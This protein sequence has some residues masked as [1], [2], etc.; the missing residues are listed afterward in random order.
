MMAKKT[1]GIVKAVYEINYGQF[2]SL[3]RG[4]S[5]ILSLCKEAGALPYPLHYITICWDII[6]GYLDEWKEEFQPVLRKRKEENE[7][8]MA[9]FRGLGL[10]MSSVPFADYCDVFYCDEP[11]ASV[12]ECLCETEEYLK[13][14]GLRDID[15]ELACCVEKFQFER[16]E[17]LLKQGADPLKNRSEIDDEDVNCATRVEKEIEFLYSFGQDAVLGKRGIGN[18]ESDLC[19][20]FGLAAH[21]KMDHLLQEYY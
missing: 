2:I 9:F 13:G 16:A 10:D 15:I 17:Q 3:H 7:K 21:E 4:S 6:L 19:D 12:E 5:D 8:F 20:L 18:V 11:D 1:N 14:L